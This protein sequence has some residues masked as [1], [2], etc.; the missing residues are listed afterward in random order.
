MERWCS[1]AQQDVGDQ[2]NEGALSADRRD[3]GRRG[4]PSGLWDESHQEI[5]LLQEPRLLLAADSVTR[6]L[7]SLRG[8]KRAVMS[9]APGGALPGREVVMKS[10]PGDGTR[11]G[12]PLESGLVQARAGLIPGISESSQAPGLKAN[13]SPFYK[14]GS[15]DSS[16]T[17]PRQPR[18]EPGS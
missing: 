5:Q 15:Q 18:A 3:S 14:H 7:I 2:G 17:L 11:A 13:L 12:P 16:L 6:V 1:A 10:D 4:R 8:H 9:D